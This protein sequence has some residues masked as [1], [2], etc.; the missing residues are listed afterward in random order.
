PDRQGRRL[1]APVHGAPPHCTVMAGLV[2]A[3]H[4]FLRLYVGKTCMTVHAGR[5]SDQETPKMILRTDHVAGGFFV[6]VGI[7]VYFLSTD[8]PTGALSMPGAGMLP[9]LVTGLMMFFGLVL[10]LRGGASAP[11]AGIAW[12]DLR[13]AVP[14]LAIAAVAVAAFQWLGFIVTM[15]LML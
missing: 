11:F 2:P 10:I 6:I 4:A 5:Q 12:D 15:T 7:V 8:L 13:H 9:K 3:I 14:V 1:E